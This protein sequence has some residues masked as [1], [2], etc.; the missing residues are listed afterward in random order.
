MITFTPSSFT[1]FTL[2]YTITTM[3]NH[4]LLN[5][6]H[7]TNVVQGSEIPSVVPSFNRLILRCNVKSMYTTAMT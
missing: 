7:G 1:T 3:Y 5:A 2:L 6:G 4:F